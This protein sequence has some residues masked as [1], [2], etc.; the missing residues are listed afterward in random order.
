MPFLFSPA[1]QE[2]ASLHDAG[3]EPG[4]LTTLS[5]SVIVDYPFSLVLVR[6]P[7]AC[8]DLW[9]FLFLE[10]REVV[11]RPLLPTVSTLSIFRA[12]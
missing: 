2:V 8:R 3:Y 11:S 12:S 4:L 10:V 5:R 1:H 9:G 6:N 7:R